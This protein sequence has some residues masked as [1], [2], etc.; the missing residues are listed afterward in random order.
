MAHQRFAF[1]PFVLDTGRELLFERG[2][3]VAMGRRA[4]ALLR[5][6]LEAYGDVVTKAA[7][8][9]A[10]WPNVYVEESNLTV[11]IATLRK[12]LGGSSDGEEWIAT[13]PR[14]GYRFAGLFRIEAPE[15]SFNHPDS[16]PLLHPTSAATRH[17][18]DME[19]YEWYVRGRSL[20]LHSP[21]GNKLARNYLIRA[22]GRE[23]TFSPSHACLGVS[24]FGDAVYY[25]EEVETNRAF[26]L[27]CARTAVSLNPD[28]PTARW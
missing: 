27:A 7:L 20:L 10:A 16:L 9:D 25:G 24:H 28:D 3:P 8:M 26:G 19:A 23:P 4:L 17:R 15:T 5:A 14:V 18:I 6:L 13:F 21:S 2:L 12:R 11:Q 22:I 1:G